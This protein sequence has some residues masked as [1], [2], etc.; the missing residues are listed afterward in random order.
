MIE[1]CVSKNGAGFSTVKEA[2]DSLPESGHAVIRI[3]NGIYH[4]KIKLMRSDTVI[5]GE[6][7]RTTIISFD[8]HA[9]RTFPTGET[10][11][12][13]NS[14]TMYVGAPDVHL[15]N[16]T[17]RNAAGSADVH[18]QS[19]A[20]YA[21]ADRLSFY[22]CRFESHQDTLLTGP[23]PKNPTPQGLNLLH[24]TL[25]SGEEEYRDTVRQFYDECYIE[26]DVDFIFGSATA[27]FRKCE[28]FSKDKGEPVNGFITAASTSPYYS[29]GYIFDECRLTGNASPR[30]V[31][32]GR[33]WRD[34]AAVLFLRCEMGEHIIPEG[35]HNWDLAHREKTIKYGEFQCTGK[36]SHG[37]R[38]SWAKT[39]TDEE[40]SLIT[41]QSVLSGSDNWNPEN[42]TI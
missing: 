17:I 20:L 38:V 30:S 7:A 1:V 29:F 4:E 6:D 3:K 9:F 13:F 23:L 15:R 39:L 18:G 22:K 8:D 34:Y 41:I 35:W 36:G 11:N 32:L 31:Y 16:I 37:K 25:G 27:Y 28:I 12:T 40:A 19:I 26:G 2:L 42:N 21:D 10:M 5:I 24:P 33:P 14:Y